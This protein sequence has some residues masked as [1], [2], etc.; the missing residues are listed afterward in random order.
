MSRKK[1]RSRVHR[2]GGRK[3]EEKGR[4][5]GEAKGTTREEKKKKAGV[6]EGGLN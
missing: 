5:V 3:W 1:M 4:G 2:K 6:E